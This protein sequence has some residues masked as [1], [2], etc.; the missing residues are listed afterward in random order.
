MAGT[1]ACCCVSKSLPTFRS[2]LSATGTFAR[3]CRRE[4]TTSLFESEVFDRLLLSIMLVAQVDAAVGSR[5]LAN[6]R[7]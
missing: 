1:S 3:A 7:K 6:S 2:A 5:G 4:G